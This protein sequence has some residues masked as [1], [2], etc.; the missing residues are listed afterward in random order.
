[1]FDEPLAPRK[2]LSITI[3]DGGSPVKVPE[4]ARKPTRSDQLPIRAK[5]SATID[6]HGVE[7]DSDRNGDPVVSDGGDAKARP[8]KKMRRR[9]KAEKQ[10]MPVDK[11]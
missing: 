4:A 8:R 10:G 1:M 11:D 9:S 5:L 6:E 2:R 3:D 7:D